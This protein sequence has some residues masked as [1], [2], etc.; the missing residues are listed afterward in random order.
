MVSRETADAV[1]SIISCETET[2]SKL[3]ENFESCCCMIDQLSVLTGLAALIMDDIL[4]PSQQII[5]AWLLHS[6]FPGVSIKKNPFYEV[7]QFIL[8][9]GTSSTNSYSQ[10]LCDII[11]CVLSSVDLD[12]LKDK[13]VH[14]ILDS[15]FQIDSSGAND[16]LNTSFPPMP[17]LSP[18]IA[19]KSD[20]SESQITQHQLLC[21]LLVDPIIWTDFDVP[22][23]RPMPNICEPANEELQFM[24]V[25]SID[26]P[27]FLFDEQNSM[28]THEAAKLFVEQSMER[29][30]LPSEVACVLEE[31][32]GDSGL[33]KEI[34]ITRPD[35]N[36]MMEMNPEIGAV[37]MKDLIVENRKELTALEKGDI[38]P[39]SVAIAKEL[40]LN[41][42]PPDKFVENYISN[43]LRVL[44]AT[45]DI[46]TLRTKAALFCNMIAALR[47]KNVEFSGQVILDL[48]SIQI[49]LAGK[50]IPEASLLADVAS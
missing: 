25:S 39:T 28:N 17:R 23:S 7:F 11:S 15:S 1:V 4:D 2:L 6:A 41:G 34:T 40:L 18:V 31:L 32:H 29:Q 42:K 12:E 16:L 48:N 27:P 47:K 49:Q 8:Q 14:D 36:K 13:S 37:F 26:A 19:S 45:R 22:F 44:Q 33:S 20:S 5:T 21:E 9:T 38:T 10:K 30:L 50:G 43:V 24:H 35:I 46:Q 3:T